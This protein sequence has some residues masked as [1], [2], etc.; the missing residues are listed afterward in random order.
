MCSDAGNKLKEEP[1]SV[2]TPN[3][4]E[5]KFHV[6]RFISR[7]ELPSMFVGAARKAFYDSYLKPYSILD[8]PTFRLTCQFCKKAESTFIC[9]D[10][11]GDDCDK[12]HLC[13]NCLNS[14]E[15]HDRLY[16]FPESNEEIYA[17]E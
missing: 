2:I 15:D 7:D 8:R 11:C 12:Y 3:L 1:S 16:S 5:D 14:C 6:R 17:P 9:L 10:R 13:E 4:T